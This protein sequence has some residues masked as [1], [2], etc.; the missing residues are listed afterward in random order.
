MRFAPEE[1]ASV[2][3]IG[4]QIGNAI[5]KRLLEDENARLAA[6]ESEM[7]QYRALLEASVSGRSGTRGNS[8][9]AKWRNCALPKRV[10]KSWVA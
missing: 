7:A 3:F 2:S 1:I 6:R 8:K 4:D 5:A 9:A 10:P